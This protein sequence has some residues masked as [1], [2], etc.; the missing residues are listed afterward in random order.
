MSFGVHFAPT[1]CKAATLKWWSALRAEM[2]LRATLAR[3]SFHKVQPCQ[4]GQRGAVRPRAARLRTTSNRATRR[5]WGKV[6][7]SSATGV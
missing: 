2:I 7:L 6:V 1:K 4:E 5:S 3:T